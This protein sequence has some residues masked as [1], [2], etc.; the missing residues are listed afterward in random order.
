MP[1][2][3][4]SVSFSEESNTFTYQRPAVSEIYKLYYQD[5]DYR[6]FREEKWLDDLRDARAPARKTTSPHR[7][8]RRRDFLEDTMQ[9][10]H[11]T[12]VKKQQGIAQAA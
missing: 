9:S 5:H 3:K 6:R 10:P 8:N 1:L 4:K 12:H 11:S 2:I 7:P